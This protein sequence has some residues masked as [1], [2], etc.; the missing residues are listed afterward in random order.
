ME[1]L[2]GL[3][4]FLRSRRARI[5]PEDVGM[6][7][8]GQRRVP[9]LRREE[10]ARLA[11]VS[12][13]Y[14]TRLEQGRSKSASPVVLDSI[15]RALRLNQSERDHLFT[16][17]S[18]IINPVRHAGIWQRVPPV[19]HELLDALE[20]ADIPACVFSHCLDILAANRPFNA[21]HMWQDDRPARDNSLPRFF[22]LDPNSRTLYLDWEHVATDVT[23]MLHFALGRH[24]D[25][26]RINEL[27]GELL[28]NEDFRRIWASQH[29]Y[30]RASGT[31]SFHHPIVGD[32][33]TNYQLLR[34]PGDL[35]QF[36]FVCTA[37]Q[38]SLSASALERLGRMGQKS[39]SFP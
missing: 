26:P 8:V 32:F 38:G 9:G 15:A 30:E 5:N 36:L 27:I 28:E 29:V 34:L 21:L 25:E 11:G 17:A 13:D 4:D 22:F 24:P 37:A 19:T 2:V 6:E 31:I 35:E 20:H 12:V 18:P 16:L 10:L 23:A 14:Y 39:S 3:G 33:S 7:G 1:R